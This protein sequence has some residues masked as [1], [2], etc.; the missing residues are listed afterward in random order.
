[1]RTEADFSG[2]I[3]K[4][5]A[6]APEGSWAFVVDNLNIHCQ[7]SLVKGPAEACEVSQDLGKKGRRGV[8]K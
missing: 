1:M 6:I 8:L 4:S 2:H 7:D 3:K 5:L